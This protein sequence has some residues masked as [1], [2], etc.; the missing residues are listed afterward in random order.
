[1]PNRLI[2]EKSP[3]LQMHAENPV[4]WYPWGE[5]ALAAAKAADKPLF[6]SIGYSA[7]HW[8]HVIAKES[9]S[10]EGVAAVLAR[11]FIAVKIDKEERPDL[12]AVYMEACRAVSGS[13]GWPLNVLA[14]PDGRPF[15]ACS[16]L[17]REVLLRLLGNI[18]RLWR[19]ARQDLVD[20]AASLTASLAQDPETPVETPPAEALLNKAYQQLRGAY[21]RIWGGFGRAP[22]F[23]MPQQLLFLLRYQRRYG[24]KE[25][26]AMA[27]HSLEMICRGGIFDQI[28]G[29]FCRYATDAAWRIPHF[30][31]MLYDNALLLWLYAEAYAETG[32]PLYRQIGEQTAAWL[33]REL[34]GAEGE[35]FGSLDADSA[36]GEGAYY[37]LT[38]AAVKQVL[39]E[40][41]GSRFCAAYEITEAG[42]FQGKSIPNL[43]ENKDWEAAAA[44]LAPAR[45]ALLA[46]RQKQTP[47]AR[48]EKVLTA[49][50][51]MLVLALAEAGRAFGQPELRQAAETAA[52]FLR[53]HLCGSDSRLFIRYRE[54]EAAFAGILDDY[55]WMGLAMTALSAQAEAERYAEMILQHFSRPDGGF[56]LT[57]DDAE[58]L[59]YRH[60]E[61]YDG[62]LPCG[63]SA[64]LLLFSRLA[65]QGSARWQAAA[66]KQRDFLLKRAEAYPV[67]SAFALA[68]LC[69]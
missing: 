10:D 45:A 17:P 36:G 66:E 32:R 60:T 42:N 59:F 5:E 49:W 67:G 56:Y 57:A 54:G 11:D 58:P 55:V 51:A 21:D 41:E 40:A 61:I 1:M 23:P 47:P 4:D 29:G 16:Y 53:Q 3:Y 39:G 52:Q 43:L 63:N 27:E 15:Y 64:A 9:F 7:C 18:A 31:K 13:G 22:K 44:E 25:A 46:E 62:A 38:P 28:G 48:D 34:R 26:L 65:A 33:L 50:N 24:E 69:E 12:D 19:E 35:F 20:T 37:T 8:C 14:L 6:L 30:E 68:A 2:R